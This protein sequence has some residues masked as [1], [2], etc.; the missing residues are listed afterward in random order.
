MKQNQMVWQLGR[1]QE[2]RN[3][4]T[5]LVGRLEGNMP[6]ERPRLRLGYSITVNLLGGWWEGMD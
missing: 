3:L 5:V 2:M 1:K 6:P 4:H